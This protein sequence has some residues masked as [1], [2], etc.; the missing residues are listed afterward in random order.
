M[1]LCACYLDHGGDW[2]DSAQVLDNALSQISNAQANGPV[3]VAL[4]L[5]H[6]V[7]TETQHTDDVMD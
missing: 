3:S 6:L 5:D 7:G 4:Q 2:V 1:C